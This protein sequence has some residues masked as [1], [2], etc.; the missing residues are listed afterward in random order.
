MYQQ[1]F[2][3]VKGILI[4]DIEVAAAVWQIRRARAMASTLPW[5]AIEIRVSHNGI[6]IVLFCGLRRRHALRVRRAEREGST[7]YSRA[8][9]TAA[10]SC[11]ARR[12]L[13]WL[14]RNQASSANRAMRPFRNRTK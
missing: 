4:S 3:S 9:P 10:S 1:N 14:M 7:S 5:S 13:L 8:W 11:L 2:F 12:N 6:V